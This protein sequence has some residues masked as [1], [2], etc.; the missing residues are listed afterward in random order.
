MQSKMF[1]KTAKK[2]MCFDSGRVL[3]NNLFLAK[4][5]LYHHVNQYKFRRTKNCYINGSGQTFHRPSSSY[6]SNYIHTYPTRLTYKMSIWLFFP[7]SFFRLA[8]K[9]AF[10]IMSAL[11]RRFSR[12][13]DYVA[14][15]RAP[16][17][18]D[19]AHPNNN[20]LEKR[21]ADLQE[22]AATPSFTPSE[23]LVRYCLMSYGI[24][25]V[26]Y[27]QSAFGDALAHMSTVGLDDRRL[28]VSSP[29]IASKNLNRSSSGS[30]S[31]S[32]SSCQ[33]FNTRKFLTNSNKSL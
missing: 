2:V 4:F 11:V 18:T 29:W 10:Q 28:L 27:F 24:L 7:L 15:T 23:V 5:L 33:N 32:L 8:Y 30:L 17:N 20:T 14:A 19:G 21:L 9:V 31:N 22:L 16:L 12:R 6:L 13:V 26:N 3:V 1:Y 25:I